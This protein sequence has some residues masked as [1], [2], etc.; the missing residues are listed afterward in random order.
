MHTH[1]DSL[2]L[3]A[4][5]AHWLE[6]VSHCYGR[7]HVAVLQP[8]A[9]LAS[10]RERL[11]W[12]EALLDLQ[13]L[14]EDL[15]AHALPDIRPHLSAA[16]RPG[17]W[18]E[19]GDLL[20]VRVVLDALR[21]YRAALERAAPENPLRALGQQL[22]APAALAERLRQSL[23]EDGQVRD[24]ASPDLARLR[25]QIQ[26][27]RRE[28]RSLLQ[29][30]LGRGDLAD[31]WQ[32][33]LVTLRAERYVLPLRATHKGRVKGIVHD[34]SASGE[35]L[36]I[37]PLD[38]IDLNN[39]LITQQQDERAEVVRILRALTAAVGEA[40]PA[41]L[42]MLTEVGRLDGVRAGLLL[43]RGY[44]GEL[45]EIDARP[46]FDLRTLRHPLLC[47]Q[48]G[49]GQVMPADL[50]LGEA[51]RQLIVTGPNTGG[52]TVL[53]KSVGLVHAM[54]YLGLPI[55]A[56]GRCGWFG[57][58]LTVIG[59]E[60]S[61]E[62]NLSTFSAQLL[63][64]R[65]VLEQAD[66]DSLVL[67]DELGSGTDPRE[68]GALGTAVAE[69]L[70][71][72][73]SLSL[74]TTH[75]EALKHY[76]LN[77]PGVQVASM[78][79]DVEALRPTH[80]LQLGRSG[81]SHAIDIAQRLALPEE[82]TGRA[83]VLLQEQESAVDRL[84][85]E[86]DRILNEAAD[87]RQSAAAAEA[88]AAAAWQAAEADRQAAAAA[89]ERAYEEARREWQDT[90]G[91]ARRQVKQRIQQLKTGRDTTGA[92][93]SL[94]ELDARFQGKKPAT[95]PQQPSRLP[96]PG[97]VGLFHPYRLP[98]TVLQVDVEHNRIQV[99][100]RGKQLWGRLD[101][102]EP[103]SGLQLPKEERTATVSRP[104]AEPRL[105]LDLRGQRRDEAEEN[106][107]RYLDEARAHGLTQVSIL[108]GTGNGVLAE[109]VRAVLRADPRVKS[110][111]MARPERGGAG[112]TE[113]ELI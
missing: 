39:Q 94:N 113:L 68:G 26:S 45:P 58:I 56:R 20:D 59:D 111:A 11:H 47:L 79:F 15:P 70:C 102:F 14:G 6:H 65:L 83:R 104:T 100:A 85:R 7:D 84:V 66:A 34:R 71:Q 89:R 33:Q 38:V 82:I 42:P 41:L 32:E 36:F 4:L 18:L 80:Q 101:Q 75:L 97:D 29:Q 12:S 73:N 107:L 93:Q 96:Q 13:R 112:V 103:K 40:A 74:I 24:Q 99:S 91:Q 77:R 31:A 87:A 16:Q 27:T 110:F 90:L 67:L 46:A 88:A 17:A 9:T 43:A 10:A 109:M 30:L 22:Q 72:R 57:R 108:H 51:L 28:I 8:A 23:D 69:A 25:R 53:L 52:K 5:R 106:L 95:R 49:L 92:A 50:A 21:D 62:H 105:Q 76:A 44:G 78:H 3:P 64:L 60:Q 37:E 2:D 81:E 1:L 19:A 63:R 98:A 48:L 86:R 61:I 35:T 54:A 55:P